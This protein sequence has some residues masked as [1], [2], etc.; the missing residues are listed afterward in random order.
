VIFW[1]LPIDRPENRVGVRLLGWT[2]LFITR[3]F[4]SLTILRMPKLPRV[5][6]AILVCN[7]TSG[8][9]PL[10]IQACLP[11]LVIW[12]MARE[13]YDI[14]LLRWV[15]RTIEAI[16][17]E[18]SGRDMAA[19]RSALRALKNGRVLG[20]F[21][22]GRI[23]DTPGMLPFQTGVA[24]M[25]IKAR[26]PVYPVYIDGTQRGKEMREAF[27]SPNHARVTFGPPVDFDRSSTYHEA[28]EAAT[29][30]IRQ[31]INILA[32]VKGAGI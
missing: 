21:P 17:V 18:R 28:L 24:L 32:N 29:E 23:P 31:A 6:P 25:A 15:Y 1:D 30:K 22:E 4:H 9:D 16:P 20:I 27:S 2:N 11:R 7:H 12:M 14:K 8:L 26:V 3:I 13:Y 10:F 19:T 5:G